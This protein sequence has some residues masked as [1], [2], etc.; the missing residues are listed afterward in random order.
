MISPKRKFTLVAVLVAA[1]VLLFALTGVAFAG[2]DTVC[3]D[4]YVIN[5]R[6]LPVDGDKIAELLG[7]EWTV[8]AEDADGNQVEAVVDKN[9][10]F[11]FEE[12]PVGE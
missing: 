6:E 10:Y 12:L 9:G 8:V 11:K 4:G 7:Q 5:H 2:G 1:L 3:V